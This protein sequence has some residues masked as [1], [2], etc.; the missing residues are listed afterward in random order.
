M[1]QIGSSMVPVYPDMDTALLRKILLDREFID[2]GYETNPPPTTTPHNDAGQ[3]AMPLEPLDV[4]NS[5]QPLHA[6]FARTT[7]EGVEGD[8]T[9]SQPPSLPTIP[10]DRVVQNVYDPPTY[11]CNPCRFEY[12]ASDGVPRTPMQPTKLPRTDSQGNNKS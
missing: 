6:F 2:P 3:P 9:P 12:F 5:P 1:L 10:E 7:A 8:I 4:T 11:I